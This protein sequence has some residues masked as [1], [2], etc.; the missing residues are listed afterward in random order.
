MIYYNILNPYK[1]HHFPK[2]TWKPPW[3]SCWAPPA[4]PWQCCPPAPSC[5]GCHS[6][7]SAVS[8]WRCPAELLGSPP[9]CWSSHPS[10]EG[11]SWRGRTWRTGRRG[12]RRWWW[13]KW[14]LMEDVRIEFNHNFTIEFG[15][16]ELSKLSWNKVILKDQKKNSLTKL[17]YN[18]NI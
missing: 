11:W 2:R 16:E 6:S 17:K 3:S 15:F 1:N 9:S 10:L 18:K 4:H 5:T 12:T 14:E 13:W 7:P 8:S